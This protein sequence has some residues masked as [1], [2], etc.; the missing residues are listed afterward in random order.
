[1]QWQVGA[2]LRLERSVL[3]Y[4]DEDGVPYDG[5]KQVPFEPLP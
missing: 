4:A 5:F 2:W 3:E 1:M